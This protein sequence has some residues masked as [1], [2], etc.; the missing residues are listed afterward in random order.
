MPAGSWHGTRDDNT[1]LPPVRWLDRDLGGTLHTSDTD[2]LEIL[3][4]R[5]EAI[6]EC[7]TGHP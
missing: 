2:H 6:I 4:I 7:V 1:A 3:F 5:R